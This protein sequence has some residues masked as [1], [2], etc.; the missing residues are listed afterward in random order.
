MA[1]C[2]RCRA[3]VSRRVS[4]GA[5]AMVRRLAGDSVPGGD[6]VDAHVPRRW[7]QP[8]GARAV[9]LVRLLRCQAMGRDGDGFGTSSWDTSVRSRGRASAR[10]TPRP[11]WGYACPPWM[12][13]WDGASARLGRKVPLP[14]VSRCGEGL[15]PGSTR[16]ERGLNL[17]RVA[18]RTQPGSGRPP[19]RG[20]GAVTRRL[21][22]A[23]R[24]TRDTPRKDL[25]TPASG[26]LMGLARALL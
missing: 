7:R 13:K 2:C 10:G 20:R 5:G 9:D 15:N 16:V 23:P 24:V 17:G 4:H 22:L 6:V 25:E 1:C 8:G 3:R 26:H 19:I 11:C 21:R 18:P 14:A 12:L